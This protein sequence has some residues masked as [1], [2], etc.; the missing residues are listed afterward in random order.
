MEMDRYLERRSVMSEAPASVRKPDKR[1]KK[2]EEK[3]GSGISLSRFSNMFKSLL[4]VD[5]VIDLDDVDSNKLSV[6]ELSSFKD[7]L[8][9]KFRKKKQDA[10]MEIHQEEPDNSDAED[11]E[12]EL[13]YMEKSGLDMRERAM[14]RKSMPK[15]PH[16]AYGDRVP[17]EDVK[18][19]L[20]ESGLSST[21]SYPDEDDEES[22]F[23]E[24]SGE[25]ARKQW[26]NFR[27]D[28][29]EVINITYKIMKKVPPET[30]R[31][32]KA[33]DDFKRYVAILDK[34]E[35]LRKKDE[36]QK[37]DTSEKG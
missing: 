4:D 8:S 29:R 2:K 28:L 13:S 6:F 7:R 21:S 25:H 23:G 12:D 17:K 32:F 18:R 11:E 19:V 1:R 30:I 3:E 5:A 26:N 22:G 31:N 14:E 9:R 34:Y 27:D 36:D 10:D 20:N 16:S 24:D 33:S 35:L 15:K 37:D